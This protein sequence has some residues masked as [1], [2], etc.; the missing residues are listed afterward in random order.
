MSISIS[1]FIPTLPVTLTLFS[2]FMTLLL[3]GDFLLLCPS[4]F[5]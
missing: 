4:V 1:Q 3:K 5:P 2:T